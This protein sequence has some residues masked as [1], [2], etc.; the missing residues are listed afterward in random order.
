[1]FQQEKKL[2][3]TEKH[4]RIHHH[5]IPVEYL[6]IDLASFATTALPGNIMQ[7]QRVVHE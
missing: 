4:N 2:K 1:M 6:Q 5:T 3:S 7:L